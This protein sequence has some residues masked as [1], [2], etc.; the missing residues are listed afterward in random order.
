MSDHWQTY[1]CQIDDQMAFVTYDHGAARELDSLPFENLAVFGIAI[2]NPTPGG[3]PA[4]DELAQLT[5]LE[6]YLGELLQPAR[7]V[8]VGRITCNG[9]RSLY[10]YT[11]LTR[12]E[13]GALALQVEQHTGRPITLRHCADLTRAGYW[14]ELFPTDDDLQ[15]IKDMRTH[16]ILRER[17]DPLTEPRE[18]QHWAYFKSAESRRA[19]IEQVAEQLPA[20][21]CDSEYE[22]KDG[23][24][25]VTFKHVGLPDWQSMNTFTVTLNLLATKAGGEYDGWE[26]KLL[27]GPAKK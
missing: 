24:F 16:E 14:Q 20:L 11:L 9:I 1:G 13:C 27:A 4:G 7:A 15:V 17:G 22:S 21:H 26:T 19:F 8:F 12:D 23:Q 18:I 6:D 10:A 3:M 5:A 25:A 2:A